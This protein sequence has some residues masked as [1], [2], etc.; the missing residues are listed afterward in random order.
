VDRVEACDCCDAGGAACGHKGCAAA[1]C[2]LDSR[3]CH[4]QWPEVCA[5]LASGLT[6]CACCDETNSVT[7]AWGE[8]CRSSDSDYAIYEGT[9]GQYYSHT[10]RVCSTG[11]ARTWTSLEAGG[12]RYWLVVPRN[13]QREGSYGTNDEGAQRPQGSPVSCLPRQFQCPG[14]CFPFNCPDDR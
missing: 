6:E 12:D 10:Q 3:C 4:G 8:T 7:L 11:G 1:V 14:P 5:D 13:A 2:S 9:I